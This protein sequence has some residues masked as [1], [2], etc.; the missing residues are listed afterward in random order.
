MPRSSGVYSP[1][2]ASFPAVSG[3]LIESAKFNSVINDISTALTQSI[4]TNGTST[5]TNSIGMN[6]NKLTNLAIGSSANDSVRISQL[7][8]GTDVNITASGL[9]A[10]PSDGSNFVMTAAASFSITGFTS[11]TFTGRAFSVKFPSNFTQT[12]TN[13]ATFKLRDGVSRTT[14]KGE[15]AFFIL[16]SVG[17]PVFEEIAQQSVI[18]LTGYTG[19]DI[20][21]GVGQIASYTLSAV[22]ALAFR[23]ATATNQI[24]SVN[25]MLDFLAGAALASNPNLQMN[26]V[27]FGSSVVQNM[28]SDIN[29]LSVTQGAFTTDNVFLLS[30]LAR[31][32][33][34]NITVS[35]RTTGKMVTSDYHITNAANS[36]NGSYRSK[37]SDTA[38]AWTSLGTIN[39]QESRSGIV[40]VKRVL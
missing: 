19:A 26:N 11:T 12:L 28:R 16:Q 40:T 23:L 1:P 20:P 32:Y 38:T 10:I 21:L 13:S 3:T 17:P 5:I 18:D 22:N 29:D 27:N 14:V 31:G 2:G 36:F 8:R 25:V 6:G 30:P 4:A 15:T 24:Y 34:Y 33:M 7:S 9:Q 39:L 37:C 35:T